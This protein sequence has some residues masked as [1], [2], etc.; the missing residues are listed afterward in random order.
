MIRSELLAMSSRLARNIAHEVRNPL[1]NVTLAVDQLK[2]LLMDHPDSRLYLDIIERSSERINLL[3]KEFLNSA[4]AHQL[5]LQNY[6][7]HQLISETIEL[8]NDR[9]RTEEI[10]VRFQLTAEDRM[11]RLDP[12]KMGTALHNILVNAINSMQ[13][14]KGTLTLTTYAQNHS[15][16][17]RIDDTGQG[18]DDKKLENLFDPF[19]AGRKGDFGLGLTAAQTIISGHK[20]EIEVESELGKGTSFIISLPLYEYLN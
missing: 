5:R 16:I 20:G 6:S 4:R 15:F 1:T 11:V 18:M 13:D 9:L 8:L 10:T 19:V 3:I 7:V 2:D 14:I 12:I 17:I